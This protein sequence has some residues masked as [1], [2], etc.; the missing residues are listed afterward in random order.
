MRREVKD[1]RSWARSELQA[2][3]RGRRRRISTR[4]L[5]ERIA[6]DKSVENI[7]REPTSLHE[8]NELENVVRP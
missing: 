7:L 2:R 4:R 1:P 8:R 6:G 3:T 5:L